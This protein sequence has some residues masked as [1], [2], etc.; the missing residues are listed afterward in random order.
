[1][2]TA[3]SLA[4]SVTLAATLS[5]SL[6]GE[7]PETDAL[8]PAAVP[9]QL[10]V[11]EMTAVELDAEL[12]EAVAAVSYSWTIVEGEGGK[13][14][15]ADRATAVFLAPKVERGVAQFVVELT[16]TYRDEPPSTRRLRIRVVPSDPEAAREGSGEDDTEWLDA[17]YGG[18]RPSEESKSTVP[19]TVVPPSSNAPSVSIG[20][21]GGSGG[22]RGARVGFRWSMS[23]PISQPVD[24]P[25]PGQTR[26]P[27]QGTWDPAR[28]VP[29]D[30][31]VE[32]FPEDVVESYTLPEEEP[33]PSE[34]ASEND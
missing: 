29:Y 14:F 31:F 33:E 34:T 28:P 16:V 24:V 10:D 22:Y 5:M 18:M 12:P 19:P 21:A 15:G 32:T 11:V 4:L 23:Y 20:V 17:F 13:L 30:E 9:G 25:P 6:A 8:D 26:L 27:G 2:R 1:M 3:R 7:G